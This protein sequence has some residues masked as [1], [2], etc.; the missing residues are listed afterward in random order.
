VYAAA[1]E[2]GVT[3]PAGML[4]DEALRVEVAGSGVWEPQNDD[5]VFRGQV[6]ARQALEQSLNVP[7]A[8]LALDTGLD[9]VADTASRLGLER[10][11]P[12]VPSM[13]LGALEVTPLELATIYSTLAAGGVRR[14]PHFVTA[15]LD[16]NGEPVDGQRLPDPVAALSEESA[17]LVT[18]VLEGVFDRG[19]ARVVRSWGMVD[20]LAGKTGTTNDRRD[21]WFAG[22]SP[23]RATLVWVGYDDNATTRLSGA[24][25]GLPIWNRFTW[26]VRPSGG[27]RAALPPPGITTVTVDPLT[28]ELATSRCP[29]ITTEY[30]PRDEVPETVCYLHASVWELRAQEAREREEG[31][32]GFR[33]WLRR[34]FRRGSQDDSPEAEPPPEDWPPDDGPPER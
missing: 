34:V 33:R 22:Y 5:K 20:P 31:G 16:P 9:A 29:A 2:E 17:Y 24:R 25:A 30:F 32:Q 12:R 13:A 19:T 21:S 11:L 28:G 26:R 27:Y 7:T 4:V 18:S 1:F 6:T 10:R 15:V 23:D 8:R 14:K 3:L